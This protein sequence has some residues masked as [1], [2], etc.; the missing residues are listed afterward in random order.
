VNFSYHQV[1]Q[2]INYPHSSSGNQPGIIQMRCHKKAFD[3]KDEANIRIVQ[4]AIMYGPKRKPIRAYR[5]S[6]CNK[7]HLTS[8]S[9]NAK[10]KVDKL[11]R[12]K[13]L[14]RMNSEISYHIRKKGWHRNKKVTY[15]KKKFREIT[16]ME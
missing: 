10:R 12:E 3:S 2:R 14:S 15:S 11:K 13:A 6:E 9:K 8:W 16:R 1:M 5:C 4:I 7:F